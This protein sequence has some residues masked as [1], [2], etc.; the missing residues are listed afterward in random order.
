MKLRFGSSEK[1]KL[2]SRL[3]RISL[4]VFLAYIAVLIVNDTTQLSQIQQ[5]LEETNQ[6]IQA[7]ELERK[8]LEYLLSK[9][10]DKEYIEYIAREKLR[11]A[12]P[13]EI[14]YIPRI[15]G[16]TGGNSAKE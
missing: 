14:V 16:Q 10:G 2:G 7:A 11:F 13:D 1:G 9:T 4:A 5:K 15:S 6:R 12:Y 3:L 8:D